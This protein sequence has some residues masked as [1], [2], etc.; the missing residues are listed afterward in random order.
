MYFLRLLI[1]LLALLMFWACEEGSS[2]ASS[3]IILPLNEDP[4]QDNNTLTSSEP[5]RCISVEV[6]TDSLNV[7]ISPDTSNAKVGTIERGE[8][9][10]IVGRDGNWV[11][12]FYDENLRWVYGLNYTQEVVLPCAKVLNTNELK[13]YRGPGRSY[14]SV[15]T[16]PEASFWVYEDD[17]NE[18]QWKRVWYKSGLYWVNTNYLQ[19]EKPDNNTTNEVAIIVNTFS[20]NSAASE[21]INPFVHM[22][23]EINVPVVS[24]QVSEDNLFRD[25]QWQ[26]YQS[27]F[28]F[29]LSAN[30]DIKTVYFRV[31]DRLG[32]LSETVSSTITYRIPGG[33]RSINRDDFYTAYRS[34]FGGLNGQQVTGLNYLLDN[35][36][37]DEEA[38]YDNYSVWI[39]QIA[40]LLA[41]VKHEVANTYTP[42][43]EYGSTYC[44]GY[45]GGCTYKGRGYVQLTHRYNYEAMSSVTGADLVTNPTRALEPDIA[46]TVMSYGSFRGIFTSRKLGNYIQIGLTD[47]YNARRV[48]NGTDKA[49]LIKGYAIKFQDILSQSAL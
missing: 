7:R 12:I 24:Y 34:Y 28:N 17:S 13:V 27:G 29:T 42:I 3:A 35:F 21:T 20:I 23:S 25:A 18:T 1:S 6:D 15:G 46:Y 43:T 38:A 8:Q 2:N 4:S 40:Y 10:I 47:Y 26:N 9:Y 32:R 36:E 49:T 19:T 30:E 41:T 45:D 5:Y 31:K 11:N 22:T 37:L 44:A 14:D 48:I 33:V 39:R 16:M